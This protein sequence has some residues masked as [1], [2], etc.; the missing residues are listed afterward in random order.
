[1]NKILINHE[2]PLCLLEKSKLYNDYEF[3][4]P[5]LLDKFEEYKKYMIRAKKEGR[6]II[7][8]NSLHEL[9]I[10]Y[11]ENRLLYW[12]NVLLPN[13]FVIPDF[14]ENKIQSIVSAK[15]WSQIF[16]PKEVTKVAVIQAQSIPEAIECYQIYKD[17]GYQK[18]AFS[19]GA[20][21]YNEISSH[22]NKDLGKALGRIQVISELYKLGVISKT[23][24]VH[25]LGTCY[26]AEFGWY[27]NFSYIESIDTSSPIMASLDGKK[28][29]S[30]GLDKKPNS[31]VNNS[32][33]ININNVNLNLLNYNVYKF[34]EINGF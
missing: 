20:S 1:M 34:R 12:I 26:P 18:I 15:K 3:I 5:H 17:L 6:Y 31:N 10:P 9:S 27:K 2:S 29:S 14:W 23:D 16:L 7:M 11:D 19:Y 28:Y 21:Y 22:P 4:L 25:L 32:F 13:E 30:F 8:D 24:R 33:E